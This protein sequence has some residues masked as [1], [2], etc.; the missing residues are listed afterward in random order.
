VIL[1]SRIENQKQ[2]IVEQAHQSKIHILSE[3]YIYDCVKEGS[4]LDTTKY[5]TKSPY[6]ITEVEDT[7]EIEEYNTTTQTWDQIAHL[8]L[9]EIRD[10]NS[11]ALLADLQ[12][13]VC[14]GKLRNDVDDLD[15]CFILD[16]NIIV[17]GSKYMLRHNEY[18]DKLLD[19]DNTEYRVSSFDKIAWI[20]KFSEGIIY[21]PFLT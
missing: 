14:F 19:N 16:N 18:L 7:M 21:S 1:P 4:L 2:E 17:W 3:Q 10:E 11:A 9:Q 12:R 13:Q 5:I 8:L 15:A 6:S 20:S